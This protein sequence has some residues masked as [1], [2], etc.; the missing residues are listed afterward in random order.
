MILPEAAREGV[1]ARVKPGHDE[2]G[3]GMTIWRVDRRMPGS[4]PGFYDP[5]P[6]MTDRV[7]RRNFH[8]IPAHAGIQSRL[9]PRLRGELYT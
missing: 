3:T 7:G 4:I 8:V 6:G 5:G 9:D 1:D 2:L